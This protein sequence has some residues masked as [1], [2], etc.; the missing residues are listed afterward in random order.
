V[1]F[2]G[3]VDPRSASFGIFVVDDNDPNASPPMR[4]R[5]GSAVTGGGAE[6]GENRRRSIQRSGVTAPSA[7][8]RT[9]RPLRSC[10][11]LG[12]VAVQRARQNRPYKLVYKRKIVLRSED[13]ASEDLMFRRLVYIQAVQDVIGGDIYLDSDAEVIR[14][15]LFAH[16]VDVLDGDPSVD[17]LMPFVPVAW[18]TRRS[19]AQWLALIRAQ[20]SELDRFPDCD[21]VQDEFVGLV[22]GNLYYGTHVFQVRRLVPVAVLPGLPEYLLIGFNSEGV[23]F[24]DDDTRAG[25]RV[26]VA[27]YGFA[28]M[29]KWTVTPTHFSL[30]V[31]HAASASAYDMQLVTDQALDMIGL[32]S[33]FINALMIASE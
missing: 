20:A 16:R 7:L 12:D 13:P 29:Q 9:P 14:L 4:G 24:I 8:A 33:D 6:A 15:A 11:F 3:I 17:A 5:A 22:H 28:D 10:D 26:I 2:L 32:I 27:S 18:R 25:R 1:H 30:Q 23:H 31:W 21:A 19:A